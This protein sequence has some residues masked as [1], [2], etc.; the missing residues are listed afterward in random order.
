MSWSRKAKKVDPRHLLGQFMTPAWAAEMLFDAHFSDLGANDLLW[1]PT[2]GTGN[3]VAAV[4]GH[5][6]VIGSEIDADLAA[7]ARHRTGREI[8]VGDCRTVQLPSGIS[9]VFGNPP[10]SMDVVDGLLE[11]CAGLLKNGQKAG[12]LL[13]TYMI[14][15]SRTVR[16]W[17]RS[18]TIMQEALPRDLFDDPNR[19]RVIS[20][21]LIFGLFTRDHQPR[22]IGFRLFPEVEENRDLSDETRERFANTVNGSRSVWRETI[23]SVMKKLGGRASLAEIYGELESG[24]KRPFTETNCHWKFQIRKQV[25]DTRHFLRVD[26]GIYELPAAA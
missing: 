22:L 14:Q 7:R 8:L 24:A 19:P 13:P 2:C 16:R 9:A 26:R 1:E 10:F 15:T 5:I 25:Q 11:R 17:N 4:P 21:P 23:I 20:K 18:W 12:L 6:P 3:C